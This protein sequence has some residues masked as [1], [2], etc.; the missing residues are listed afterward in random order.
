MGE[1]RREAIVDAAIELFNEYGT[2]PV[3]TN[4]IAGAMGISPGNLYY[5]FDSKEA[6]IRAIYERAI[7]EYD[8]FWREAAQ[9]TP[10][11]LTVLGLL[12]AIFS[13]QWK[14]RCLQREFPVLV[15][16]DPVLADRYR[17]MQNARVAFYRFLC[18][19]WIETG[20]LRQLTDGELDDLVMSTWLVG[21]SWLGY[22]EAMGRGAD[23]VEVRRGARLIYTLLRPYLTKSAVALVEASGWAS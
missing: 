23:E 8:G 22:L 20:S 7:A 5:H 10:D 13:H 11:P 2:R 14:Y 18:R 16:Q 21:E 1:D 6:V 15:R 4:H 17:E 19:H 3:T 9:V 12:D